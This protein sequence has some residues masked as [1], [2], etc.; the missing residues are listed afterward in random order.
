MI[1]LPESLQAWGRPEFSEVLKRELARL[2]GA[3]LPLQQGLTRGSHA[4]DEP[5]QVRII[6]VAEESTAL[7]VTAGLF[8]RGIIAGCSCADDPTPVEAHDEYCEVRLHIDK[9]T[10]ETTV[11]L[12]TD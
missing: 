5:I 3:H 7:R 2:G 4:L 6:A 11:T 12:V 1:R 9:L 8:Y 10:A